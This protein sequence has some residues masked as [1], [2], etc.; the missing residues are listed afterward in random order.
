MERCRC[1]RPEYRIIAKAGII[2]SMTSTYKLLLI[3]R[4]LNGFILRCS[5][6]DFLFLRIDIMLTLSILYSFLSLV[7]SDRVQASLQKS[8]HY[9]L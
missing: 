7:K 8:G 6:S 9:N 1:S 3:E 2:A 5:Y 4:N